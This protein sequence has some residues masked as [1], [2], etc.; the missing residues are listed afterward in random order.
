MR[1]AKHRGAS[2]AAPVVEEVLVGACLVGVRAT[3]AKAGTRGGEMKRTRVKTP[4]SVL[5]PLSTLPMV[6]TRKSV[7]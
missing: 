4:T 1:V 7:C 5:F 2:L 3:A 6:A